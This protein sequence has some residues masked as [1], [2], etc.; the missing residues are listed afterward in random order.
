MERLRNKRKKVSTGSE[1]DSHAPASKKGKGT[2]VKQALMR[3]YPPR[4]HEDINEDEESVQVHVQSMQ[5]EMRKKKPRD[6]VLLPLLKSTYLARRDYITS[7]ERSDVEEILQEY[8]ALQLPSA[9]RAI[10][11]C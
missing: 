9:V 3:R 10:I 4:L 1:C 6:I 7:D 11:D 8:P 5:S 2:S